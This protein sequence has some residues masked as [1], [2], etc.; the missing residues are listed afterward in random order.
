ME[1]NGERERDINGKKRKTHRAWE[2][3]K[4]TKNK[5]TRVIQ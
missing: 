2:T 1:I 3:N 4:Q 5:K